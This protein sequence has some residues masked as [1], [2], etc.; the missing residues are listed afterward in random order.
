MA[1]VL[2]N[3]PNCDQKPVGQ[4][5]SF[6]LNGVSFKKKFKGYFRCRHCDSL[7]RQEQNESFLMKHRSKFWLYYGILFA[8]VVGLMLGLMALGDAYQL[9]G[10]FLLGSFI[11]I[12]IGMIGAIDELRAYYWLIRE[13][14]FEEDRRKA[15]KLTTSGLL[16]FLAYS[17]VA[18][19]AV[20][21][22][23]PFLG[24]LELFQQNTIGIGLLIT[25]QLLSLGLV[26]GGA[27]WIL[28]KFSGDP[29]QPAPNSQS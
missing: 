16:W 23:I 12:M 17:V 6:R 3:C 4:F 22:F 2:M 20:I 13:A 29:K 26:L 1:G 5:Y 10:E 7:L 24:Q 27:I 25:A 28:K 9:G 14:D 15:K 19:F 18:I 8:I 11:I 21:N